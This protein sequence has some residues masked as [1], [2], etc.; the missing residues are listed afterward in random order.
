MKIKRTSYVFR[1]AKFG[2][3]TLHWEDQPY[4]IC[5]INQHLI[6]GIFLFIAL[7]SVI[8]FAV[9]SMI[10]PIYYGIL[11]MIDHNNIFP[12]VISG[13]GI[14]IEVGI[15]LWLFLIS[16]VIFHFIFEWNDKR[17]I[18]KWQANLP[19]KEP[20]ALWLHWKA[21]RNKV[22]FKVEIED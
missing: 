18:A 20:S 15:V 3:L 4:T 21:F 9:I 12:P 19:P 1:L 10:M 17:T 7:S 6:Y 2:G 13:V 5:E 11:W 8:L 22:C 14:F 16:V